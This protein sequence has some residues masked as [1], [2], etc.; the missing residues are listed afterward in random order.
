MADRYLFE[1][2]SH[3]KRQT[4]TDRVFAPN[5]AVAVQEISKGWVKGVKIVKVEQKSFV[6][7]LTGTPE[8]K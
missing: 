8:V 6:P 5:A 4:Y 3:Y 2:T 7:C 1:V